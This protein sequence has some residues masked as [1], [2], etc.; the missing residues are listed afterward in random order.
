VHGTKS[1]RF[2]GLSEEE[3]GDSSGVS[4]KCLDRCFRPV[5]SLAFLAFSP[6]A[7][8]GGVG[9]RVGRAEK[10]VRS[11]M[12]AE[13]KFGNSVF[14]LQHYAMQIYCSNTIL[15]KVETKHLSPRPRT[16][17]K[18]NVKG[19]PRGRSLEIVPR[20]DYA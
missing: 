20:R 12:V 5:P 7:S 16:S 19:R 17:N 9:G 6:G 14:V 8:L 13:R 18:R 10:R 15:V 1:T 4:T 2:E 11:S 3:L